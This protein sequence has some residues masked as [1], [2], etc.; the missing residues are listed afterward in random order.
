MT[1]ENDLT[2]IRHAYAKQVM[3]AAGVDNSRLAAA[4]AAVRREDYLGPGPWPVMRAMGYMPTPD[5]DPAYLYADVLVG[6]LPERGLNN[7]M[8]SFH[9]YLMAEAA[10]QP[11]DHVVHVGA[12]TGYYT[13]ILAQ[14]A[15]PDGLV[16]AIEFDEGL[17]ARAGANLAP[18]DTVIVIEGDGTT[19]P[20]EPA[21]MIYINA[22]ATRPADTWLDGLRDGGRLVLPL[23]ARRDLP[24]DKAGSAAQVA[25]HGAVF[26]ITRRADGY[27]ARWISPVGIYP[28]EGARDETAEAAIGAALAG[29]GWRDVRRLYRGDAVP[30][31]KCWLRAPGWCLAYD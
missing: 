3:A 21:D 25:L 22:G 15:G 9:A 16:T 31:D 23:T 17:A 18:L 29:G 27:D 1:P 2:V 30:D 12:G 24:R 14:L 19:V 8:P 5:A 28:C 7:G 20:F 10:V 6:L 13:A 11:G 4:F 26:V